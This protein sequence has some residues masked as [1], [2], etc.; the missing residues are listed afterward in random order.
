MDA[1][2]LT[3]RLETDMKVTRMWT[4]NAERPM[5]AWDSPTEESTEPVLVIADTPANAALLDTGSQMAAEIK[6]LE[7]WLDDAATKL[8]EHII[9]LAGAEAQ[10]DELIQTVNYCAGR[11][12][13]EPAPVLHGGRPMM[14]KGD[15]GA[16][17]RKLRTAGAEA[18]P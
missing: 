17:A 14:D 8:G 9:A 10:R 16:V 4:Q 12:E 6:R 3:P 7:S 2:R 1:A 15:V 5:S 13:L 11:L 18:T